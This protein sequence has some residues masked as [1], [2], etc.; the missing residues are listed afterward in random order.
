MNPKLYF[1]YYT[2]TAE[3]LLLSQ[4][5][6]VDAR[7]VSNAP[8]Q[9]QTFQESSRKFE[10]SSTPLSSSRN[11]T[12]K[13]SQQ[14]NSTTLSVSTEETAA[15]VSVSAAESSPSTVQHLRRKKRET[16]VDIPFD[17]FTNHMHCD[18][19]QTGT[20]KIL[21]FFPFTCIWLQNNRHHHEGWFRI[22]MQAQMEAFFFGQYYERLRRFEL[23]PHTF[24]YRE[25]EII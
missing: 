14:K 24:D 22:Y 7:S 21:D 6:F 23:D 19:D 16:H 17:F 9:Q 1:I 4:L 8:T 10:G 2:L 13:L 3:L 15:A 25:T 20:Y 5:L 11:S 12:S 18:F